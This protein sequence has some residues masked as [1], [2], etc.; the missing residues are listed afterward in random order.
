MWCRVTGQ[1]VHGV[2][3]NRNAFIFRVKN[4]FLT[5]CAEAEGHTMLRNVGH[6]LS[7]DTGSR[8]GKPESSRTFVLSLHT[9]TWDWSL[10]PFITV[11]DVILLSTKWKWLGRSLQA[12]VVFLRQW[13]FKVTAELATRV[14]DS[15]FYCVSCFSLTHSQA[16]AGAT[17]NCCYCTLLF[18]LL[19]SFYR[20]SKFVTFDVQVFDIYDRNFL[21]TNAST[22]RG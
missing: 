4:Y 16:Y 13:H 9:K 21:Y 12:L 14:C 2:T 1:M 17:E 22:F 10:F 8:H 19:V 15:C 11:V 7:S 5:A 3:T 6:Y 18:I 20:A